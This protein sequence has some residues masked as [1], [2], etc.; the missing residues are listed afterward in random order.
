MPQRESDK[1]HREI[2]EILDKLDNFVPE[3]R[4]VSKIRSKRRASSEPGVLG[5]AW[6]RIGRLTLGHVMLLGLALLVVATVFRGPL[7][8]F[9]GPLL[10]LGLLLSVGAFV[11]SFVNR[12]SRRTIAGGGGT[13]K[14]WRGQVIDYD[15]PSPA[16][17]LR[18]WFRRRRR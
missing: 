3:E 5:R 11:L 8:A 10:I 6:S 9:S 14:R 17:K 18:D 4:L 1:V 15:E 2:E 12:D 7:G 16:S 13:E